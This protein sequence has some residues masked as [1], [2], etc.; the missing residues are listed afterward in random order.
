MGFPHGPFISKRFTLV[1]HLNSACSVNTYT[2]IYEAHAPII[3]KLDPNTR[4]RFLMK[5]LPRAICS[6]D[7]PLILTIMCF[8]R[9]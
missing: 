8:V 4:H 6:I 3:W 1:S 7:N 2:G 5:V 9:S